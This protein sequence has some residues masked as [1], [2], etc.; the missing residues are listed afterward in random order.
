MS[1]LTKLRPSPAMAVAMAALV[2][3]MT[4]AAIALPGKGTVSTNDIKKGAIKGKLIAPGAI[5]GKSIAKGAVGSQQIKGKSIKGNRI[6]D[7]GIKAK[8]IADATITAKKIEDGT[9]TGKQVAA[10]GLSSANIVDLKAVGPAKLAAT[11]G[12]GADA[13]RNAAPKA[14]LF[15]KGQLTIYAKCFRDTTADEVYA[16]VFIETSANGAIFRSGPDQLPG[17]GAATAFLN[18]NTDEVERELS[19]TI[20]PPSDANLDFTQFTATSADGLTGLSGTVSTG[21]KN[22]NLGGGN[23]VYGAGNGCLFNLQVGG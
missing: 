18:T 7:G 20:T 6:K 8:Q 15:K 11:D 22:G 5:K 12:A 19:S 9:I 4:G 16:T 2:L 1:A 21:A 3:G 23:G 10:N 14:E 17:G 13:A